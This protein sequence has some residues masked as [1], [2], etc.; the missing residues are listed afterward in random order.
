[1]PGVINRLKGITP[2]LTG[3]GTSPA[4]L[5]NA[6]DDD[7]S[8]STTTGSKVLGAAGEVGTIDFD[9]GA[10]R[11]VLFFYKVGLWST[12]GTMYTANRWSNDGVT[13]YSVSGYYTI[14]VATTSEQIR[15]P[16][17]EFIRARFVR[18]R[19]YVSAAATGYAKLY[20]A[21]ALEFPDVAGKN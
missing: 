20:E 7:W 11:S 10:P 8:T 12:A 5:G 15:M 4:Q 9:L 21:Q 2:T 3:W 17:V 16:I 1:M 19:F 13:W 6:T 18:I 14:N